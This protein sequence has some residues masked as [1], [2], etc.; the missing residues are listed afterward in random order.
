[1]KYPSKVLFLCLA[2]CITSCVNRIDIPEEEEAQLFIRL[3]MLKG[4]SAITADFKTTNNLNGTFPIQYPKMAEIEIKED[5]GN[6]DAEKKMILVYDEDLDKYVSAFDAGDFLL[7]GREYVL[8]ANLA[9]SGFDKITSRTKVPYPIVIDE[10]ELIEEGTFSDIE[11]NAFWQGTIGMTFNPNTRKDTRYGH[12][13]IS[14]FKTLKEEMDGEVNYVP[15]G[16]AQPFTLVNV[17]V[18]N[19]AITDIVHRDGFFIEFDDLENDYIEVTLQSPIPITESNQIMA[20]LNASLMSIS[21]E[22]YDY[23][24]SY[25]HIIR[26]QGNIFD[27]N[28]LYISNIDKGLGLFSSCVLKNHMLDFRN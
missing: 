13:D 18:G 15:I 3:E 16:E 5:Q 1:L 17:V 6:V 2:I 8:T 24:L 7:L 23:H 22:H 10:Y 25:H 14:G 4:E 9:G 21:K 28:A 19:R 20:F 27:E 26:S 11:G 12:L